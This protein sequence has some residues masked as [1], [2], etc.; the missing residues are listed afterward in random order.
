MNKIFFLINS[1]RKGGAEKILTNISNQASKKSY[2]VTIGVFGYSI[3]Y[4]LLKNIKIIQLKSILRIFSNL[5]FLKYIIK[6]NCSPNKVII[7]N[8]NYANY[9]NILLSFFTKHK[10]VIVLH[11][12][13]AYYLHSEK[14]NKYIIYYIHYIIQ[15][16]LFR[17][18]YKSISVS[19]DIQNFYKKTMNL[20]SILIYNPTFDINF[21]F[22]SNYNPFIKNKIN[23][24][25][26]GSLIQI[27]NHIELFDCIKN[28][29]LDFC[30]ANNVFFSIIGDGPLKN[31]LSN[32]TIINKIDHLVGFIGIVDEIA[33]Y[34]N[35]C[36][37]LV[38]TSKLEGLPTVIIE[39]INYQ[40]P[41]ISS[42]Q[43]GSYEIMS[44]NQDNYLNDLS[45]IKKNRLK[46][47]TGM[48]Y[49]LGN[50]QQLSE[51]LID[52]ITNNKKMIIPIDVRNKILS[53]FSIDN[54]N[55]YLEINK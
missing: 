48:M 36:N 34:Y 26:V 37:L 55:K 40:K 23:V 43:Q 24:I 39:S 44:E 54:Y 25:V 29:L 35:N 17:F 9:F 47:N 8:L 31:Y 14:I 53:K 21:K 6:K 12:S 22:K 42:F 3:Q 16:T 45:K 20:N 15:K 32:Y 10:A 18:S 52:S 49:E 11:S 7:S 2:Q 33:E 30:N 5:L 13:L 46:L 28:Y 27:K 38:S 50:L 51:C 41:V 19:S 4:N 1:L